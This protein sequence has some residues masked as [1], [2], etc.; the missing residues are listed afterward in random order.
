MIRVFFGLLAGLLFAFYGRSYA[1]AAIV[2][3]AF[4][5]V[6]FVLER[7]SIVWVEPQSTK[8]LPRTKSKKA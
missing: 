4:I 3:V 6:V 1:I 8:P 2:I 5:L 7:Y